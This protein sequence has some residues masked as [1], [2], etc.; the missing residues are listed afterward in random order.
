MPENRQVFKNAGSNPSGDNI[1]G[2]SMNDW[3][4]FE[5]FMICCL[6]CFSC[7]DHHCFGWK[8]FVFID[9]DDDDVVSIFGRMNLIWMISIFVL[10]MIDSCNVVLWEVWFDD[11]FETMS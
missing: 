6:W 7:S 10:F 11:Y 9:D 2:N 3:F 1:E 8:Y 5:F 4:F